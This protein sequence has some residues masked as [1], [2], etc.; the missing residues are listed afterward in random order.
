M[1]ITV[2]FIIGKMLIQPKCLSTDKYTNKTWT[3]HTIKYY[4]TIEKNEG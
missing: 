3:I 4:L 1:F 2:F